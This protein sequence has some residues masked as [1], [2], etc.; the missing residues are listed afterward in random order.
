MEFTNHNEAPPVSAWACAREPCGLAV[1]ILTSLQ[2]K[3]IE[4]DGKKHWCCVSIYDEFHLWNC[5]P[6]PPGLLCQNVP[7]YMPSFSYCS[8]WPGFGHCSVVD[9]ASDRD[10][11][12]S[13]WVAHTFDI[14]CHHLTFHISHHLTHIWHHLL[15]IIWHIHFTRFHLKVWYN[16]PMPRSCWETQGKHHDV[17]WIARCWVS[18]HA[19]GTGGFVGPW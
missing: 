11:L 3:L 15:Y 7:K 12:P 13:N 17:T 8:G 19:A 5:Q 4:G 6:N 18:D 14:I 10:A 2:W 9:A 16:L 1:L